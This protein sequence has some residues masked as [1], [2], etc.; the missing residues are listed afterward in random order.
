MGLADFLS[1]LFNKP[2]TTNANAAAQAKYL[3]E[4]TSLNDSALYEGSRQ[5]KLNRDLNFF[6]DQRNEDTGGAKNR[7]PYT[8]NVKRQVAHIKQMG[9]YT[10]PTRFFFQFD[11]LMAP[12]NER[13]NRNCIS[14]TL[15][16]RSLQTQ[17]M[18]M[19][20]PP[21]EFPY[22]SNYNNE[23]QMT[24]RIGQDMYERDLFEYWIN[25]SMDY[26]SQDVNYPDSYKSSLTIYKTNMVDEKVFGVELYDL[27]CKSIGDIELN[28]ESSDQI[29]T[30]TVTF[31]FTEYGIIGRQSIETV[32]P[33]GMGN[34]QPIQTDAARFANAGEVNSKSSLGGDQFTNNGISPN[35]ASNNTTVLD[36]N[37]AFGSNKQAESL[38][39]IKSRVS[40]S[41]AINTGTT[42]DFTVDDLPED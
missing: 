1:S 2:N 21:Q 12:L 26:R 3:A 18:K 35:I 15:P 10:R 41:E 38:R 16:G 36:P 23:L 32:V 11:F 29:S 42:N 19:Y 14:M 40:F 20:G 17:P 30:L 8:S 5:N 22:E 28:T 34:L 13:L 25:Q 39:I 27:F 24:F 9:L 7:D 4:R 37:S 6:F 33:R 31:S